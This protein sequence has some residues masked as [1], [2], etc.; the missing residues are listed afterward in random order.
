MEDSQADH[1]KIICDIGAFAGIRDW[2]YAVPGMCRCIPSG[3]GE[4]VLVDDIL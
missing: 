3:N 2:K 1:E 4:R